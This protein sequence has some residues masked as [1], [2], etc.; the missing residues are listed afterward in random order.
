MA[1]GSRVFFQT[2]TFGVG[3]DSWIGHGGHE[4]LY[5]FQARGVLI[6]EINEMP[7]PA[8]DQGKHSDREEFQ[9]MFEDASQRKF[10]L[11]L[12]WSLDR[13]GPEGFLE[14]LNHLQQAVLCRRGL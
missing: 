1:H 7:K 11:V 4:A 6:R 12:F 10:D 3:F 9:K 5:L 14:T 2:T 13:F 8:N